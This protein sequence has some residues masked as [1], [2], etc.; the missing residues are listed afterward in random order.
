MDK[1][2]KDHNITHSEANQRHWDKVVQRFPLESN[3]LI[4]T[5]KGTSVGHEKNLKDLTGAINR[6]GEYKN[7]IVGSVE[8]FSHI[9]VL[10]EERMIKAG[11]IRQERIDLKVAVAILYTRYVLILRGNLHKAKEW[12]KD[13]LHKDKPLPVEED[14]NANSNH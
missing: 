13:K 1:M 6:I 8:S 7:V 12:L 9:Q 3:S 10:N 2:T 4:L 14:K 5:L 11:W